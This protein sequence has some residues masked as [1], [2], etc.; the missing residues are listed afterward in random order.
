M[1]TYLKNLGI[2]GYLALEYLR[3]KGS[4]I[5]MG[6]SN[7]ILIDSHVYGYNNGELPII[8][9]APEVLVELLSK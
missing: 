2:G 5:K 9:W 4:L 7:A 8:I 1:K 3:G 6:S